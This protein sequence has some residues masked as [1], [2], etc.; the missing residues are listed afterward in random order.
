MTFESKDKGTKRR[1]VED[2]SVYGGAAA[3][4]EAASAEASATDAL[5]QGLKR[6]LDDASHK[7]KMGAEQLKGFL[8][9]RIEAAK[10]NADAARKGLDVEA[11]LTADGPGGGTDPRV[12]IE[13]TQHGDIIQQ[14][15]AKSHNDP[16][17][18][19]KAVSDPKFDG[20]TRLVPSDKAE[21]V[22]E[23]LP[24]TK[25][26]TG[27][28]QQ[29]GASSGGTTSDELRRATKYPRP[30]TRAQETAQVAREAVTTAAYATVAGSVL[31]GA[32]SA[33]DNA[34]AYS[35]GMI[36]QKQAAKNIGGDAAKSGARSGAAAMLGTLIRH[37]AGKAG[38]RTLK[39]PGVA[40]AVAAGTIEAGM[41]IREYAKGEITEDAAAERLG[42]TAFT[43]VS[44][45]YAGAAAGAMFGPVGAAVGSVA[46]YLLAANVYQSCIGLLK[47]TRLT[48]TELERV[49][50]L[51]YEAVQI[52]G[53]Q[54][55]EFEEL[56][57]LFNEQQNAFDRDFDAVERALLTD[58]A[59]NA[60]QPLGELV[61][62]CGARLHIQTLQRLDESA[63]E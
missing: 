41:V 56:G 22:N 60:D 6:F 5:G 57:D 28:L 19:A 21:R 17:K 14:V 62:T 63:M 9:E 16:A 25:R 26:V 47:E 49:E 50:A 51:G 55:L 15:Q 1:T 54:R 31:G 35:Q 52:M 27:E 53:A 36:D 58:Q 4:A 18:L 59:C 42:Q 48:G 11:R 30:F 40:I 12:D 33:I 24:E 23:I 46:G 34:Y 10:F 38:L 39:K 44:G 3:G 61:T 20:T 43:T 32:M 37:G 13:I 29:S 2:A 8:F 45:I 7:S